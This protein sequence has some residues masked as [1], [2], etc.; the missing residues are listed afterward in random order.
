MDRGTSMA[1]P[2]AAGATALVKQALKERFPHLSPEQL[3]VLVKQMTMSTAIPHVDE[4]THAYSL[5]VSKERGSWTSQQQ[6]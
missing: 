5:F 3:Q 4:E 6:L 1:S 2:H